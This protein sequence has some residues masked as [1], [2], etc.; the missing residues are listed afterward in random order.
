MFSFRWISRMKTFHASE[1]SSAWLVLVTKGTLTCSIVESGNVYYFVHHSLNVF[2]K[3]I[4]N[5]KANR[6]H[7]NM[8]L[9]SHI[10]IYNTSGVLI[11]CCAIFWTC[12]S[13]RIGLDT[14]ILISRRINCLVQFIDYEICITV[15]IRSIALYVKNTGGDKWIRIYF[16]GNHLHIKMLQMPKHLLIKKTCSKQCC[17]KY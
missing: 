6:S 13:W 2:R 8:N 14:K 12:S 1:C 17:T 10:F 3:L 7:G 9:E 15:M 4:I 16:G 5:S 11:E